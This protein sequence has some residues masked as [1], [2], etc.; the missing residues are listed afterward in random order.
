[1]YSILD[2]EPVASAVCDEPNG[3]ITRT[4]RFMPLTLEN[5]RQFWEKSRQFPTLFGEEISGDYKKFL[6]FIIHDGPNG[7]EVN[8]LFWVVDDFV[9][10]YYMTQIEP[11]IDAQVHYSFFDRRQKGRVGLSR[12]MLKYAF[13]KFEFRRFSVE[14]PK[15]VSKLTRDFIL[16]IGFR[17]EGCKR[18]KALY[19]SQWFDV[20]CYGLL[21]EELNSGS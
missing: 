1:M 17:K 9:G 13:D 19:K 21:R 20:A 6:N 15:F 2:E 7:M 3:S 16:E 8:G 4:V 18:Q 12:A 14:V 5:L 10:M 11:G